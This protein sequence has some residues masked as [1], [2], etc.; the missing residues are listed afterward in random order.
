M[1]M[2]LFAFFLMN[3]KDNIIKIKSILITIVMKVLVLNSG[4]L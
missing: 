3:V 4:F 1:K 2:R